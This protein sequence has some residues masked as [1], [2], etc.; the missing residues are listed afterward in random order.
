MSDNAETAGAGTGDEV[1]DYSTIFQRLVMGEDDV[2]GLVAYGLYKHSKRD[3]IIRFREKRGRKPGQP[4]LVGYHDHF[5]DADMDRFRTQAEA[6]MLSFAE[7]IVEDRRNEF[8]QEVRSRELDGLRTRLETFISDRTSIWK[9]ISSNFAAWVL[10][11]LVIGAA[12]FFTN[13]EVFFST[14]SKAMG[15]N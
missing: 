5:S 1:G 12:L 8:E 3:W 13:K 15:A 9:S 6:K 7:V 4:D 11:V 10:T 2:V 14:A